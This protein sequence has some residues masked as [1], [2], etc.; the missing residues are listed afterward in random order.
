MLKP[1]LN[2]VVVTSAMQL[3]F[4]AGIKTKPATD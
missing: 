3:A 1:R 4:I 2:H